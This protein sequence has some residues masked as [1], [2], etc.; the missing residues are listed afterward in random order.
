MVI[1][2][3]TIG[4]RGVGCDYSGDGM[5][6]NAFG[7]SIGG[8]ISGFLG[9][10]DLTDYATILLNYR[11][12]D[13]LTGAD[14]P[15]ITIGW[16]L[17]E[18]GTTAGEYLVDEMSLD[19]DLV[20]PLVTFEGGIASRTL[21]A[22]PEDIELFIAFLPL[23]IRQAELHGT[24]RATAG[25]LSNLDDG[26]LCG[27]IPLDLFAGFPVPA[28]IP[29]I[30]G[31]P[32]CEGTDPPTFGD[33]IIAGAVILPGT[34]PDVD[35]DGDGLESFEITEGAGCQAVV[36][37]CIDGDGTRVEG[38]SCLLDPRFQDGLSVGLPF[39]AVPATIVGTTTGTGMGGAG[40]G[41]GTGTPGG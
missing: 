30:G 40:G 18:A 21:T 28:D 39:T 36:T 24:T 22:G 3:L 31:Q 7:E 1:D 11:G 2:T 15:D 10:G 20:S 27:A 13:D 8:L 26:L 29:V 37:A 12:L 23:E 14:D 35:L 25:R 38:R 6:D 17:G 4:G 5:P 19:L 41:T 16:M 33:V 34:P 32:A 9:G